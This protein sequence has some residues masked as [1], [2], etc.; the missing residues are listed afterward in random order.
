VGKTNRGIKEVQDPLVKF[1]PELSMV[2]LIKSNNNNNNT[3]DQKD[4]NV[5]HVNNYQL[6]VE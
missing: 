4:A 2:L 3:N 1:F 6:N 5:P